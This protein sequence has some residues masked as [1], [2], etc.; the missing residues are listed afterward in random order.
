MD[1]ERLETWKIPVVI[2]AIVAIV[3]ST[4][5]ATHRWVSCNN[6]QF[7]LKELKLLDLLY[8]DGLNLEFKNYF[9]VNVSGY[10]LHIRYLQ[11]FRQVAQLR[12]IN[13]TVYLRTHGDFW[14]VPHGE[15]WFIDKELPFVYICEDV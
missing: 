3:I 1:E 8:Y 11:D 9:D 12:A 7:A 6:E 14:N 2:V 5:I 15:L 4:F 10:R 13:S